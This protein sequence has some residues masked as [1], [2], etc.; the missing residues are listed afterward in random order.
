MT[1]AAG[2]QIV[3]SVLDE[4]AAGFRA[5]LG[6]VQGLGDATARVGV[7]LAKTFAIGATAAGAMAGAVG[8]FGLSMNNQMEQVS[9]QLMAFTKDGAKTAE[10]L[11]MIRE[12]AAK[13]PFSFEQMATAAAGLMPAA[14][15]AG[16][17]LEGLIETA[18]ILAASNPAQGLEGAA[19]ALREAVSGDFVSLMERFNL[20]RTMINQ[21]KEEGLP[22]LEIVRRAMLGVG[23][24]ADLVSNLAQT[25]T[26]R[27]STFKDTLQGLAAT[28]TQPI[29]D[30][31]SGGLGGVNDWLER[32][33]PRL[34][35]VAV[36]IGDWLAENADKAATA[37]GK[38][39][40][41]IADTV[42]T[43]APV[44]RS[45]LAYGTSMAENLAIGLIQGAG[46]IVTALTGIGEIIASWLKPGSPPKLLPDLDQWGQKA[47]EV[48]L[49]GW[50]LADTTPLTALATAIRDRL[51]AAIQ[52]TVT[53][54]ND[55]T[56]AQERLRAESERMRG[57]L[58]PLQIGMRD[59]DEQL[60]RLAIS[61]EQAMRPLLAGLEEIDQR[62]RD[63]RDAF[64]EQLAPLDA[65]LQAIR[66]RRDEIERQTRL[67]EI[68]KQLAD[69]TLDASQ[70]EL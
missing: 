32:M 9:A 39:I 24:D 29:F 37:L 28:I 55:L 8:T 36:R 68:D 4:S 42:R 50:A 14:K 65:E 38:I 35:E 5:V 17:S 41:V 44:V 46:Y 7:T 66:D 59:L 51:G 64:A 19:F 18:E 12:R 54:H 61:Q 52:S 69:E 57:I 43:L 26:G 47:A 62:L 2:L 22:N 6:R 70:R 60:R 13:T 10:I 20:P 15:A 45:M 21:L 63:A 53:A 23:Y 56:A 40:P 30:R 3:I 33:K 25:A 16:E 67:K 1:K 27:W 34:E 11:D 31:L 49:Q 48:Y 58:N